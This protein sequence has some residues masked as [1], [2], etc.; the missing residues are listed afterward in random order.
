MSL[1]TVKNLFNI[2]GNVDIGIIN[3]L[4]SIVK[5]T[6]YTDTLFVSSAG[7][8][9]DGSSWTK[10]YTS[11]ISALDWI[12]DN[13]SVGET[14]LVM[15]GDGT[16]DVNTTGDPEYEGINVTICGMGREKTN[17]TNTHASATSILK[18][19]DCGLSIMNLTFL[20]G[21]LNIYALYISNPGSTYLADGAIVQNVNFRAGTPTGAHR[22]VYL[23][24]DVMRVYMD[25]CDFYGN[26]T[27]TTALYF[28]DC[29]HCVFTNLHFY[30]CLIGFHLSSADDNLNFFK[31]IF[32]GW[33]D[34]CVQIDNAGA[35]GNYF[36]NIRFYYTYTTNMDDASTTSYYE[37]MIIQDSIREE[38]YP[39]NLTGVAVTAGA[40]ANAYGAVDTE[41]RSAVTATKP[42]YLMGFC[43][44]ADTSEKWAV[45]IIDDTSTNYLA[46][47][48]VEG[49][50]NN[51]KEYYFDEP[52]P[53][54]Q[55]EAINCS[56][57][58]ETGG[59][60]MDIW[61]IIEEI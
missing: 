2:H 33:C 24:D 30:I 21:D 41:I 39:D 26:V 42:F 34:T 51:L 54:K 61:I 52:I 49:V 18:F 8:N 50:I 38:F 13:Q 12:K 29:S 20:T 16:F 28:N 4:K 14:H 57:K 47:V 32:F 43:Y 27:H 56:V 6:G 15:I 35:A 37:K 31:E 22:F 9:S 3:L 7:D 58:S 25:N 11:P 1:D 60:V 5:A 40:G 17:I 44:E 53:I 36:N 59:N 48:L 55:G 19:D 23:G 45:R 46:F 10:A